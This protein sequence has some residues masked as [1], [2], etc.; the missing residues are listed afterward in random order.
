MSQSCRSCP[1]D[2]R[3]SVVDWPRFV[4]LIGSKSRIALTSHV[5]PDCDA[6][7][8]E[9]AMAAILDALGKETQIVNVPASLLG[10][11]THVLRIIVAE[12][13]STSAQLD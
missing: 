2:P 3:A 6:I 13:G 12:N 11:E 5:R 7:G 8:S 4:E 9:L 1:P 10:G